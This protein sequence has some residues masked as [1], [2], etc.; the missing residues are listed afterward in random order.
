ME[1]SYKE[2]IKLFI[3]QL[4]KKYGFLPKFAHNL[5]PDLKNKVYY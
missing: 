3:Q 4:T 2:D 5:N 1:N